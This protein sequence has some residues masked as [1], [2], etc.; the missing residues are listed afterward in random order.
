MAIIVFSYFVINYYCFFE[1]NDY[2]IF[3]KFALSKENGISHWERVRYLLKFQEI[4]ELKNYY[5]DV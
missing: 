1:V 2:V 5:N 4:F 3:T